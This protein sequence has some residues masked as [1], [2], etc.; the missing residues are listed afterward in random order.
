MTDNYI[1]VTVTSKQNKRVTVSTQDPGYEVTATTDTGKFWANTAE[2]WATSDTIV[3]NT[4]YSS[5]YYANKA[6]VSEENTRVYEN[7]VKDTYNTFI[8]ESNNITDEVRNAGQESVNSIESSRVDAVDSINTV[9][10]TAVDSINATKTNILK[11]IEFVAEGEK[12][13]IQELA[14]K[15]KDDIE[16][17]GFYMRDDKLYFINSEGQEEEFKSGGINDKITNCLLEVPQNIKIELNNGTLTLKA[18]SIV[19]VPNGFEDDGK[20]PK[21]DYVT[22]ESDKTYSTFGNNA[23]TVVYV[24]S[25][26]E[27]ASLWVSNVYSGSTAPSGQQ[28]MLWYDTANNLVKLTA[29]SGSTWTSGL[30]LPVGIATSTTTAFA[31]IDQVFNSMGYIGSTVWVDKGVKGLIPNGRN[32]DGSLI[33]QE[34]TTPRIVTHTIPSAWGK[35]SMEVVLNYNAGEVPKFEVL[36]TYR[37][38]KNGV[39]NTAQGDTW[40]W[41]YYENDNKWFI[42]GD[43]GATW[44]QVIAGFLGTLEFDGTKVTSFNP[45]KPFRAV[46]YNDFNVAD[47]IA[48]DWSKKVNKTVSTTYTA[49]TNGYVIANGSPSGNN[50]LICTINGVGVINLFMHG[51]S[52]VSYDQC[53]TLPVAKGDTYNV[54]GANKHYYFL[55]FKEV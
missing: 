7:A 48:V 30:A 28:Y 22:V 25:I 26:L 10:N 27:M 21:F 23:Q 40:T 45:K 54:V 16:S 15:A 1:N 4:D 8:S 5:K 36:P 53:F 38:T 32:E 46:D 37:F 3:D 35:K 41:T 2:K 49:E 12:E 43:S 18:G 11:D 17:T 19:T 24:T 42:S 31:S 13:E 55:P 50:N 6:K 44:Y 52:G 47:Y 14:D 39:L 29:N 20:T 51:L 33:N 9:K 34:R